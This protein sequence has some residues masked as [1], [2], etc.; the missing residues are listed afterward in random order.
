MK[1]AI[2]AL[3]IFLVVACICVPT[4]LLFAGCYETVDIDGVCYRIFNHHAEVVNFYYNDSY[5]AYAQICIVPAQ[6]EYDDQIYPVTA[7]GDGYHGTN[8]LVS[9]GGYVGELVLPETVTQIRFEDYDDDSFKYLTAYTVHQDNTEYASV[10]G[11]LFNKNLDTLLRYPRF[12]SEQS[13]TIPKQ[14]VELGYESGIWNNEN[15]KYI[16]VEQGNPYYETED[17]I[18]YSIDGSELVY[19]PRSEQNYFAIPSTVSVV[20][21]NALPDVGN[22]FVPKSV[23]LFMDAF[24]KGDFSVFKVSNIY[25]EGSFLPNYV[26]VN[27]FANS[28]VKTNVTL[29][30]FYTHLAI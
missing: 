22:L 11:V 20:G 4:L 19:R 21:F 8:R 16:E 27:S 23:T 29:E 14:T 5:P 2:K 13:F 30:E 1:K 6:I 24:I 25:F 15:L 18:L 7:I 10:N 3:L 26:T 9:D 12:N 28:N 17:N